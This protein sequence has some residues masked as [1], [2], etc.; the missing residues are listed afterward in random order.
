M[1]DEPTHET[2]GP[3]DRVEIEGLDEFGI[4]LGEHTLVCGCK[5]E[6]RSLLEPCTDHLLWAGKWDLIGGDLPVSMFKK[7]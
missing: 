6:G 3:Y 4:P 7:E 5:M 2:L 1:S